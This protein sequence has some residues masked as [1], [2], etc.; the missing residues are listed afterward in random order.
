M[1][2][3][4]LEALIETVKKECRISWKNQETNERI[5]EIVKNSIEIIKHKLGM[6]GNDETDLVE[7]GL[8]KMLLLK[9]CQY[10][11][12]NMEAEFD[13]NYKREI[14]TQRHKYEVKH[15]KEETE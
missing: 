5:E 3:E 10:W 12:S 4:Q 1:D 14:L 6:S 7:P 15:G 2:R 13:Q 11:W 9:Y 8:T